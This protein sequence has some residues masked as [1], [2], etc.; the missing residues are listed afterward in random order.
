MCAR[1][2]QEL[3]SLLSFNQ[4]YACAQVNTCVGATAKGL[5]LSEHMCVTLLTT[6]AVA[7]E[8]EGREEC[9]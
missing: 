8:R 7:K 6:A 5:I 3:L 9:R 2:S 4:I 1:S